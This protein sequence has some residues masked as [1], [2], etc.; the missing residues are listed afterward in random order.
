MGLPDKKRNDFSSLIDR[1]N[2]GPGDSLRYNVFT[3][4]IENQTE[5]AVAHVEE[6]CEKHPEFP[7]FKS[8]VE[9]NARHA[10]DLIHAIQAKREFLGSGYLTMAK[11]QELH[12]KLKFHISELQQTLKR[13]EK[14]YHDLMVEDVRS[15][16]IVLKTATYCL[17]S[18]V[19]LAF[20]LDMAY[21]GEFRRIL[22]AVDQIVLDLVSFLI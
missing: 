22:T 3:H 21:H 18:I 17:L 19:G 16:V 5:R 6:Y 11:E 9:R 20:F 8:R 10:I 13:M 2:I 12:E 7:I 4:I 1:R 15:T 14:T